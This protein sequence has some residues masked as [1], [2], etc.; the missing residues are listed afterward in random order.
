MIRYPPS[1]PDNRADPWQR[2]PLGLEAEPLRSTREKVEQLF[3]LG[4]SQPWRASRLGMTMQ[5][6]QPSSVVAEPLRPLADGR[7]ADTEAP[8]NLGLRATSGAQQAASG[9]PSLFELFGSQLAWSPHSYESNAP[10]HG[11]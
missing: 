8:C 3:P 6:R 11:C 7:R 10:S 4:G 2:P 1:L 9:E 5:G